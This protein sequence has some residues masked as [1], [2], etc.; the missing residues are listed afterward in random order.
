MVILGM[1]KT[2]KVDD[3]NNDT[4]YFKTNP[5]NLVS[6]FAIRVQHE[7]EDNAPLVNDL[8]YSYGDKISANKLDDM[9]E[10]EEGEGKDKLLGM[11]EDQ[12]DSEP[13]IMPIINNPPLSNS[14]S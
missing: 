5:L 3:T 7:Q 11:P 6:T 9:E 4:E 10:G 13:S 12:D 1:T 8:Q 2:V 14:C